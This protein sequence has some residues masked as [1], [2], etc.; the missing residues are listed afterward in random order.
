MRLD[1]FLKVARIIKRR[2][3]ANE[4]CSGDR[5]SI[6]GKEAKP[7]KEIKI[8]DIISI[9]FGNNIY[10]FRIKKIP[11]GNIPKSEVSSLYDIIEEKND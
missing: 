3:T 1:K 11:F 8:G 5:V 6:N 2:T 4:A 10:S 7:S 9:R